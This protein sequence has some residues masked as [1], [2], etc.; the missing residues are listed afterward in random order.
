[1][2]TAETDLAG[3]FRGGFAFFNRAFLPAQMPDHDS[4]GYGFGMTVFPWME[5][6]YCATML[7]MHKNAK[8][9][10]QMGFYN[11]DRRVNVKLRPLK[12]GKWWPAIAVGM[13]DIGRF[14]H[15]KTGSN[16]NNHF[17]NIYAAVSKNFDIRGHGLG[18]HIVYRYYSSDANRNRRGIAGGITYSP[19][20]G[21]KLQG[22]RAWL[23]KPRVIVEWDGAGVNVG[24]DV[25]LWRH[26]FVQA[27]LVHGSA[28]MGGLSY[29][30]TIKF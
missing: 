19:K 5:V 30:Y 21:A 15:I 6:S 11:E 18:A 27:C 25:L 10:A 1:M 8:K 3:T 17:Q 13:D 29:H 7:W 12:E 26:L 22:P 23:Q 16:K 28:F 9:D 24:G 4:F 20:L 2:P 14:K